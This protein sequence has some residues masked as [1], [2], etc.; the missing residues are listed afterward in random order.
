MQEFLAAEKSTLQEALREGESEIK[1]LQDQIRNLE[2]KIGSMDHHSVALSRQLES[3]QSE[4][5]GLRQELGAV[6]ERAREMLLAQGAELSRASVAIMSLTSRLEHLVATAGQEAEDVSE[7]DSDPATHIDLPN[8]LARRSSQFLITP[9][10]NLDKTEMLSEFSKAMMSTSTGSDSMRAV[11]TASTGSDQLGLD[12]NTGQISVTVPGLTEQISNIEDLLGKLVIKN[13]DM[14]KSQHENVINGNTESDVAA[15]DKVT[16]L[17]GIISDKE[18]VM[19]EM[20][21][22]FSRNRQI[23]TNNW[24]QAESEVRRLDDIYHDTVDRVV[25]CLASLPELTQQHPSLAKLVNTLQLEKDNNGS[26]DNAGANENLSNNLNGH[27]NKMSRSLMNNSN[28]SFGEGDNTNYNTTSLMSQSQ[29]LTNSNTS[30]LISSLTQ[31]I[32]SDPGIIKPVAT[33]NNSIP[34][35]TPH[36]SREDMNAN[37]SL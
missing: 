33:S 13:E 2:S 19:Q 18:R 30:G 31:S 35:I 3:K 26:Q 25:M 14:V 7:A 22:K 29:V 20:V 4:L 32:M 9:T 8:Q 37:Q 34:S 21:S 27:S 16:E 15:T 1:K 12:T 17:Q 11:M 5:S 36:L 24:E 23:L 6:K 10:E 28:T